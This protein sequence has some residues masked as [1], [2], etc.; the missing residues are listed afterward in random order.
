[1]INLLIV[2][3]PDDEVLGFGGTGA[4]LVENGD[5]V[6]PVILCANV[7]NRSKRPSDENLLVDLHKANKILGFRKPILGSFPNLSLNTVPHFEIVKF[8]EKQINLFQPDRVFTHHPADLNDDHQKISY[9]CQVAAR[10]PQRNNN[11]KKIKGIYF[12]EILSSTDW[13]FSTESNIFIPNIFFDISSTIKKKT[14]AL[15]CYR[16]VKRASPHPRSDLVLKG[17][18]RYRG[19]Q[20]GFSYAEAFQHVFSLGF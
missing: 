1:M 12:I 9:A 18:A 11:I 8:I 20:S 13:A 15:A 2:A 17:H 16:N 14:K 5:I 4:K 7:E 19:G 6:Q 3:H 10:L